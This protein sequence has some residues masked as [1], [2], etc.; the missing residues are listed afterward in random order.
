MWRW[1]EQV[2]LVAVRKMKLAF[3]RWQSEGTMYTVSSTEREKS[4][5]KEW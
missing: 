1:N 3:K 5:Q 4:R 2:Q